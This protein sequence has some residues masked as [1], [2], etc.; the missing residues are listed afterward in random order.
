V[1]KNRIRYPI[2]LG[3]SIAVGL[4]LAACGSSSS[5]STSTTSNSSSG[6]SHSVKGDSIVLLT[7]TDSLTPWVASANHTMARIWTAAGI[8][9]TLLEDPADATLQAQHF[10]EA[11][12]LH[13]SLILTDLVSPT[14]SLPSLIQA[15]QANIPVMGWDAWPS[16]AD[17]KY[18][19]STGTA[20]DHEMGEIAAQELVAG[21]QEAGYKKGNILLETGTHDEAITV[22]R[23]S[24]FESVLAKYPQYKIVSIQDANWEATTAQQQASATLAA[25]RSKGGIQGMYGMAD[26]MALPMASAAQALGLKVGLKPGDVV[27]VGGNCSQQGVEAVMSGELAGDATQTP[28]QQA[29]DQA[30]LA[31]DF[32]EGKK[33]PSVLETQEYAITSADASKYLAACSY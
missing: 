28:V 24:G 30:N 14:A 33:I 5:S 31:I 15:K 20:N 4:A 19:V 17:A 23:V 32:L 22:Y 12:S 13:P 6:S 26:Y 2:I 25:Y 1:R 9:V 3:A 11:I 16:A 7:G 18:L 10:S 21:L 8:K 29:T 27:V